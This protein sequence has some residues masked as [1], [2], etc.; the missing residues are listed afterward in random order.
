MRD[1]SWGLGFLLRCHHARGAVVW[2]NHVGCQ[3][4]TGCSNCASCCCNTTHQYWRRL[5]IRNGIRIEYISSGWRMVEVLGS[6]GFGVLAGSFASL[7]FGGDSLI[8]LISGIAVLTGLRQD[9]SSSNGRD[10]PHGKKTER[11]TSALLFN[12]IPVIG[13]GSVFSYVTGLKPEG[14]PLGITV[15]VG[16]V[17]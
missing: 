17:M 11:F 4:P 13:L 10:G 5:R 14:S 7:A 1:F 3:T 16:A 8:E 6:I 2:K 12:L 15:S 9:S